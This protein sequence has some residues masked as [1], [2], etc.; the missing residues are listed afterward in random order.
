[1]STTELRNKDATIQI[2]LNGQRLGGSFLSI[3]GFN[4]K[5]EVDMP[6]KR[7]T[8]DKRARADLDVKGYGF[9]FKTEKRDHIWWTVWKLIEQ[10]ELAGQPLP[11]ISLS[12]TF[13]Y[14][15]G[16]G[17]LRTIVLHGDLVMHITG[18]SIPEQYQETSWT[19]YCSFATG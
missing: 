4:L 17:L 1:M 19:G 15:D 2:K 6:K 18:D 3:S 10:A 11:V 13:S 14:R 7:F 8:G 16:T 9:D 5:P 12:V